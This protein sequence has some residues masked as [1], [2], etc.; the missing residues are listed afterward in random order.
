ME[1]R[2]CNRWQSVANQICA[3]TAKTSEIRC[4]RL[5]PCKAEPTQLADDALITPTRILTSQTQHQL[6]DLAGDRRSTNSARI[7]PAPRHEPAVP[8]KQRCRR[9]D[10]RPPARP[11][12]QPTCRGKKESIGRPQLKSSHLTA[13]HRQLVAEHDDLQLLERVRSKTQRHKLQDASKHDV[14]ERTEQRAAPLGDGTGAR[15]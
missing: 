3:E 5:R 12:Q 9:D 8:A 7:G 1:P 4:R 10:K 14:A 6:T 15:L 2:G 13:Q 11:R